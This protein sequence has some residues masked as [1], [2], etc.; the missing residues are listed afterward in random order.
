MEVDS[1]SGCETNVKV[2]AEIPCLAA[3]EE[4]KAANFK[5]LETEAEKNV[6]FPASLDQ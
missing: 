1:R 3:E 2:G 5:I 4:A 6:M